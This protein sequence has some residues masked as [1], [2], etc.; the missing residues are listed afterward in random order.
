MKR[1]RE[2]YRSRKSRKRALVNRRNFVTS[3]AH[4]EIVEYE[5]V[6]SGGLVTRM[7]RQVIGRVVSRPFGN[8]R[9][10]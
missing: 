4:S 2:T 5:S 10:R 3:S 1:Q 8:T 9:G 7:A 6:L